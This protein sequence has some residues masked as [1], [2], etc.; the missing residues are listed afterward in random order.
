MIFFYRLLFSLLILMSV[1]FTFMDP[2][3]GVTFKPGLEY[4]V[5]FFCYFTIQSNMLIALWFLAAAF[6][7]LRKGR[8][9]PS[10]W[11]D[12]LYSRGGLLV[13]GAITAVV[14]WTM[15]APLFHFK[16]VTGTFGVIVLHSAAPLLL[17][18]DLLIVRFREKA[19]FRMTLAWIAYPLLYTAFTL[20][21]GAI[22][23]WYPYFFIDPTRTTPLSSLVITL[24][25]MGAGF[26]LVCL[27]VYGIYVFAG[28]KRKD[29]AI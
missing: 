18:A 29:R 12:S 25:A 9:R 16:S 8:D 27:A 14:Y 4:T 22:V 28:R 20:I 10:F 19:K 17:T 6:Y 24:T 2:F 3:T 5:N 15:L 7:S 21:R 1:L 26:Y 13:Y 11:N 23:K